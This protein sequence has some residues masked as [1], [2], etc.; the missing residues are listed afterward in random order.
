MWGDLLSRENEG[1]EEENTERNT[2][3][4]FQPA[5]VV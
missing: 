2:I 4:N 1:Y 5:S 3:N